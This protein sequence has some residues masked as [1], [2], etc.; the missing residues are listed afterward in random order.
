[1]LAGVT[2]DVLAGVEPA[3]IAARFHR[4]VAALVERVAVDLRADTG[5]NTVALSGGVFLN[6]V[7]TTLCRESLTAAGFRVLCHR[8]VPPS[9]AGLAL[10]Q[11]V[12][13]ARTTD[14]VEESAPCA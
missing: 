12:I 4:A 6:A 1:V 14:R 2:A 5:L 10:G 13:A 8:V 7:L 3:V 9:D 11:L